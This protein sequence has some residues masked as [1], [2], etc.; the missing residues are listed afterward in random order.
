MGAMNILA[1]GAGCSPWGRPMLAPRS[2]RSTGARRITRVP[3]RKRRNDLDFH[4]RLPR[5]PNE[6]SS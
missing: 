1:N 3:L 4:P 6:E 5:P 2:G